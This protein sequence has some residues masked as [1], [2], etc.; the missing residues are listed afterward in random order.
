VACVARPISRSPAVATA[1]VA[2]GA[3]ADVGGHLGKEGREP[4]RIIHTGFQRRQKGRV[5]LTNAP[6]LRVE[7]VGARLSLVKGETRVVMWALGSFAHVL[8]VE[9][10]SVVSNSRPMYLPHGRTDSLWDLVMD[11]AINTVLTPFCGAGRSS[12]DG[13]WTLSLNL[14]DNPVALESFFHRCA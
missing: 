5:S 14:W 3:E 6:L 2:G 1:S 8:P 7:F 12:F 11:M 10:K 4:S 13:P 9:C